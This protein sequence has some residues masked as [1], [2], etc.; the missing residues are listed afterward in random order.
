LRDVRGDDGGGVSSYLR[1]LVLATETAYD[2]VT[3]EAEDD[4]KAGRGVPDQRDIT[5]KGILVT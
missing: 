4:F 3:L 2:D 1:S 5:M